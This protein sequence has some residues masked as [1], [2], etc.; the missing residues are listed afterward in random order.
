MLNPYDGVLMDDDDDLFL[1]PLQAVST[2]STAAVTVIDLPVPSLLVEESPEPPSKHSLKRKMSSPIDK[3]IPKK[4]KY[5]EPLEDLGDIPPLY[6]SI[7]KYSD[8]LPESESQASSFAPLPLPNSGL[9]LPISSETVDKEKTQKEPKKPKKTREPKPPKEPKEPKPPKRK[10]PV[11]PKA[12]NKRDRPINRCILT[13]DQLPSSLKELLEPKILM[14]PAHI[15]A[16]DEKKGPYQGITPFVSHGTQTG[17]GAQLQNK[18]RMQ[19]IRIGTFDDIKV[20]AIAFTAAYIDNDL[21]DEPLKARD[22]LE[23]MCKHSNKE[24]LDDWI[25]L[26][27]IY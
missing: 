26:Q 18:Q 13:Y 16:K 4:T 27:S 9:V 7:R 22:W 8:E 21:I 12:E 10:E 20:A 14:K 24:V 23:D 19:M 11:L 6:P 3:L 2:A 15:F 25:I 5:E 1:A 17:W